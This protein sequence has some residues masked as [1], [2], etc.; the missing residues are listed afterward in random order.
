MIPL[1]L[2][3]RSPPSEMIPAYLEV[4]F[5]DETENLLSRQLKLLSYCSTNLIQRIKKA[6]ILFSDEMFLISPHIPIKKN[7][8]GHVNTYC[9]HTSKFFA[10]FMKI[11]PKSCK[12]DSIVE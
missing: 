12:F 2:N 7:Y 6:I 8:L 5:G 3:S 4:I 10:A 1:P 9:S 11:G